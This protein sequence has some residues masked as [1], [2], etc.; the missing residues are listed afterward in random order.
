MIKL[1]MFIKL[2][3]FNKFTK[4]SKDFRKLNDK[5]IIQHLHHIHIRTL[6]YA[7][8]ILQILA[9][10]NF[11]SQEFGTFMQKFRRKVTNI[12]KF[13][14]FFFLCGSRASLPHPGSS[15]YG[16]CG[17]G[18]RESTG[19]ISRPALHFFGKPVGRHV[20]PSPHCHP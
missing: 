17:S 2:R 3:N 4:L 15:P 16:L 19:S 5:L 6:T 7:W 9:N 13:K 12:N 1:S 8:L 18:F 14:S 20:E 11:H 10:S